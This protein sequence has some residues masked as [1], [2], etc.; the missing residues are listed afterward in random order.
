MFERRL[1]LSVPP[2]NPS[3]DN[4]VYV[5]VGSGLSL[6]TAVKLVNRV[7]RYRVPEPTRQADILSREF[8]RVHH[9]TEKQK[10]PKKKDVKN[11]KDLK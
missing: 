3:S 8:L 6:E 2:V 4:P 10:Q 5:S 11:N 7:S 9:P 1:C